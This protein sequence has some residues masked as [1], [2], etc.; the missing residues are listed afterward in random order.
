MKKIGCYS[1]ITRHLQHDIH[2]QPCRIVCHI[3]KIYDMSYRVGRR[4][5]LDYE[6]MRLLHTKVVYCRVESFF[7]NKESRELLCFLFY[8]IQFIL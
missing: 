1:L 7:L 5:D 8:L 4:A 2:I 3:V 6:C